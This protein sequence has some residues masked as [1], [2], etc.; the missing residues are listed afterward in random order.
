MDKQIIES[1]LIEYLTKKNYKLK[2]TGQTLMLQCPYC[3]KEQLTAIVPPRCN[4]INCFSCQNKKKTIF[5]LVKD[6]EHIEK[7]EDI[8]QYIKEFLNLN[9]VTKR[10]QEFTDE[11]LTFYKENNFDLVAV[12]KDGKRPIENDWV[13]KSHIEPDEWKRWLSDGINIGIKTGKRSNLTII[14]VDQKPVPKEI[15]AL[16]GD[17]FVLE[18]SKGFQYYYKYVEDLPKTRIN[19]L[20]IDIE[21]D[22]GQCVAYPSIVA[23]VQRKLSTIKPVIEMPKELKDYLKSKTTVPLKSLSEKLKEDIETEDFNLGLLEE[24]N[25]NVSLLKLGGI[26]RKSLSENQTE[27]V[28]QVLNKHICPNPL[29][30]KE[31]HAM[32]K[33]LAR[34]INF[35]EQELAHK[36]LTYLKDVEEANRNEIAMTVVGTNKGEEKLRIDK[37][38]K[39]LVKE[40]YVLKKG[41]SYAIIKRLDWKEDLLNV[42]KPIDFKMPYFDDIAYFNYGDLIIIGANQKIGKTHISM[43]IVK[44]LVEQGIT[45]YYINLETGSRFAKIA[46]QL[47]L[48]NGDFKH[49]FCADPTQVEL[50]KNAVT[51]IDW[52]LIADKSQTDLVFKHFIEQLDKQGGLL[53]VFQQLKDDDTWFAPNMVVQFPALGA[54]YI[55]DNPADGSYGKFIIK[56]IRE[57]KAHTKSYEIPCKYNWDTKEL[58]RMDE[59]QKDSND[60]EVKSEDIEISEEETKND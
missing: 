32:V 13:N 25:R 3:K 39:Y 41:R 35:D 29:P 26:L 14:D 58:I 31:I 56:P 52:L 18:T 60:Q 30:N 7:E 50:E 34:Y 22:G 43:N 28:M 19:E 36:V 59:V 12:I 9:I 33:S 45:P 20:K 17:T 15:L 54:R 10:D 37:A 24:G 1:H 49:S 46:L 4:F 21:N 53:I 16:V 2:K 47:G 27:E 44:K 23:G 48:K 40:G 51:I 42:G 6:F 5:D 57:P 55:Y 8:I 11:V 38:L